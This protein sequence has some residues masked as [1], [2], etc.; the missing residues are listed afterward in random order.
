MRP[1]MRQ[2]QFDGEVFHDSKTVVKT[3][4]GFGYAQASAFYEGQVW[5]SQVDFKE[6]K[7]VAVVACT[8][9]TDPESCK[10]VY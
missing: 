8:N 1:R 2:F 3:L 9:R 7:N 4:C 10:L 6:V 5:T